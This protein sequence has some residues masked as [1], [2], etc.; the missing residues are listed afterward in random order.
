[1]EKPPF[2]VAVLDDYEVYAEL[3]AGP[4]LRA[5]NGVMI[6][7][8]PIDFERLLHFA[9]NVISVGLYRRKDAYDRPIESVEKDVVG[10]QPL[11]DME[12]YPAINVVPLVLIGTGLVE[13]DVPTALNY[14]LFLTFPDDLGLYLPKVEE[15]ATKVK[16]RRK[17]SGY[18]CPVCSSRL[19]Y[20]QRKEDLF[21]PRCG[22][23]VAIVDEQNCLYA[24]HGEPGLTCN[25]T[26]SELTPPRP[27]PELFRKERQIVP[28]SG[29]LYPGEPHK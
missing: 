18:L 24:P 12:N 20:F 3:L 28:P 27:S 4:L 14:D 16:T 1:M 7:L 13:K 2:N 11:I 8:A 15:L 21:C 17:L 26:L 23:S 6:E 29:K 25:C 10:F 22:T 19:V 9:P 5:G